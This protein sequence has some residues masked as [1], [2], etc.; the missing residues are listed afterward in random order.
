MDDVV[1]LGA[2]RRKAHVLPTNTSN[3]GIRQPTVNHS[4]FDTLEPR[5]QAVLS[6]VA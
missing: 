4:E 3:T 1:D 6:A 2:L 5:L